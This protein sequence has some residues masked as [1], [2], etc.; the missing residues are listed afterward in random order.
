MA[1]ALLGLAPS[2]GDA[3][4]PP[5]SRTQKDPTRCEHV[6]VTLEVPSTVEFAIRETDTEAPEANDPALAGVPTRIVDGQPVK[7]VRA[8]ETI[9]SQPHDN[10]AIQRSVAKHIVGLLSTADESTWVVR[11][12]SRGQYGWTFTYICKD[13]VAMW[14]RQVGK[15]ANK[16]L[17]GEY[18]QKELEPVI[19][20]RPA[21]DCRGT[22]TIAF[23]KNSRTI[24]IKYEHTPFHKT[25][26]EMIEHFRPLPPAAPPASLIPACDKPKKAKTPRKRKSEANGDGTPSQPKKKRRKTK[27]EAA[28]AANG[29]GAQ[30]EAAGNDPSTATVLTKADAAVQSGVHLHAVLDVPP[31]EAARRR[32]VA[33]RLLSDSGVD[34]ES[35]S[36]EQFSIFANQSP[37]LQKESLAMLAK[38]GAERLRIKRRPR[39]SKAAASDAEE[40]ELIPAP[41]GTPLRQVSRGSCIACRR[42]KTKAAKKKEEKSSVLVDD[43]QDETEAEAEPEPEPEAAPESEPEPAPETETAPET[44]AETEE[45]EPDDIETIDYTSNM[46]VAN[47]ITPAAETPSQDYFNSGHNQLSYTHTASN[48]MGMSQSVSSY[49]E[50]LVSVSYAEP[51]SLTDTTAVY[52]HTNADTANLVQPADTRNVGHSQAATAG[53]LGYHHQ[54]ATKSPQTTGNSPTNT[55]RSLPSGIPQQ[56]QPITESAVPLPNYAQNWQSMSPAKPTNTVSSSMSAR[57]HRSRKSV[58]IPTP[59]AVSQQSAAANDTTQQIAAQAAMH[60]QQ[61]QQQQHRPSPTQ[62]VAQ[63]AQAP[64]VVSPFQ[65]PVQTVRAKSRAGHRTSTRTPVNEQRPTVDDPRNA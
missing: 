32:E 9:I 11:E 10:P 61:Q 31:A 35:L 33:I 40:E 1:E 53:S 7:V 27:S 64:R 19:S 48:D 8:Y 51:S 62:G 37:D 54:P 34:P 25:V 30:E 17:V 56:Q 44:E 26:G 36:T 45:Q 39:K 21:F 49:P 4:T 2:Y 57:Q 20:G 22:L 65:A 3:P 16:A 15:T 42:A 52:T 12:V 24:N 63:V 43:D 60:Q 58:Q 5:R 55:R 38:Y 23:S 6:L 18:S 28:A 50:T 47:M 59:S 46:P 13:S 41:A 29:Q 14:N